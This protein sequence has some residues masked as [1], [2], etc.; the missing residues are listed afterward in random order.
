MDRGHGGNLPEILGRN[1][2]ALP[3]IQV[4]TSTDSSRNA[5][6]A[7]LFETVHTIMDI[8]SAA[9][10]R[11]SSHVLSQ[12]PYPPPPARHTGL[13]TGLSLTPI[14]LSHVGGPHS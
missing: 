1:A 13:I 11:V 6:S 8:H 9:G 10:L 5:G 12:R 14:I 2:S 3:S 4:A 7:V